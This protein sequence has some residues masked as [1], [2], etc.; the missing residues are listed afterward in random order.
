M[1]DSFANFM[2]QE[3]RK[4]AAYQAYSSASRGYE[5]A[6]IRCRLAELESQH[7]PAASLVSAAD[8]DTRSA[9]ISAARFV[10]IGRTT[11]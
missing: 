3:A 4:E 5:L 10:V 6:V 1:S 8:L 2:L 9:L 11:P 7:E